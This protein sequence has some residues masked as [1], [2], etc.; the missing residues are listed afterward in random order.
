MMALM[1]IFSIEQSVESYRMVSMDPSIIN[2]FR[3][4]NQSRKMKQLSLTLIATQTLHQTI[5]TCVHSPLISFH[6]P[7][8]TRHGPWAHG[9]MPGH[10]PCAVAVGH[11]WSDCSPDRHT[12]RFPVINSHFS[13]PKI[14]K[15]KAFRFFGK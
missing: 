6:P 2:N 13:R 7:A 15:V 10:E 12:G 4:F 14:I 5:C 11:V 9:P 3:S 1:L 8:Q